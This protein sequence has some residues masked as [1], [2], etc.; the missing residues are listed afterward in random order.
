MIKLEIKIEGMNIPKVEYEIYYPLDNQN[1]TKLNLSLCKDTKIDIL[2]PVPITE[3]ISKYD[4][5]KDYYNDICTKAKSK[6]GTDITLKDRKNE[7]IDN[8]MTLCE[9]DCE[10]VDYDYSKEKAKCSCFVKIESP[11]MEEIKFD[12]KNC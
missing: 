6:N 12:K 7:F 8:N 4:P 1:F 11:L 2:I 9:E 5:N 10:L 3:D